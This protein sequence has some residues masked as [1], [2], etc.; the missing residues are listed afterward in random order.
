[1]N[2]RL[3]TR[4]HPPS[5][6]VREH[7]ILNRQYPITPPP[8]QVVE[9]EAPLRVDVSAVRRMHCMMVVVYTK[10]EMNLIEAMP[11]RKYQ[12]QHLSGLAAEKMQPG[13][14]QL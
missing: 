11:A 3:R 13:F 2:F 8:F 14:E 6:L 9:S 1:M 7:P 12:R 5:L 10:V 4:V